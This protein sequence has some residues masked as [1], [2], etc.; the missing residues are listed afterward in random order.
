[1]DAKRHVILRKTVG[2]L[3]VL[4]AEAQARQVSV[5]ELVRALLGRRPVSENAL[6]ASKT[7]AS[8]MPGVAA[9]LEGWPLVCQFCHGDTERTTQC[10]YCRKHGCLD[11]VSGK[12]CPECKAKAGAP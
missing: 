7:V 12:G 3:S 1:M 11:C 10:P 2:L 9:K 6:L 8:R 5:D 4:Q